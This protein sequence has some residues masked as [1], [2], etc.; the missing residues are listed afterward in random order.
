[1]ERTEKGLYLEPMASGVELEQYFTWSYCYLGLIW[2]MTLHG[3]I[4]IMKRTE[5]GHY[6]EPLA[7]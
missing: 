1:M 3:A 2:N 5:I 7:S 6:L 4:G